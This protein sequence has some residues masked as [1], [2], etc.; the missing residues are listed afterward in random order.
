MRVVGK[1]AM[2]P[3]RFAAFQ[4][5][6]EE[7]INGD[8]YFNF[9]STMASEKG[10]MAQSLQDLLSTILTV[11]PQ[12]ALQIAQ[13]LDPTKMIDEIQ[14]LRGGGNTSRFM[15][16]PGTEPQMAA[17]QMAAPQMVNNPA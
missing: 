1:G 10:F 15:Y 5:T 12:A 9:D 17:P 11:N 4:G 13:K 2:D 7:I 3:A 8:D 14:Y 6:P 16:A